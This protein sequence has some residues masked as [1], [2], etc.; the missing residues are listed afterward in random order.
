MREVYT[1]YERE[2]QHVGDVGKFKSI[3]I[4]ND[5]FVIKDVL[6]PLLIDN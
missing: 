2:Y 3:N 4:T 6:Y 5:Y 1:F